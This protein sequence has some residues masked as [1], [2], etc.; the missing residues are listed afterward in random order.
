MSFGFNVYD[1]IV[2]QHANNIQKQFID[3]PPPGHGNS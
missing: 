3:A 2:S 1:V